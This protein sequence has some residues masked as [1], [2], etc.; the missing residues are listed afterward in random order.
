MYLHKSSEV[1]DDMQVSKVFSPG[2][3]SP[4][5]NKKRKLT[6]TQKKKYNF[7][8]CGQRVSPATACTVLRLSQ[9]IPRES[10]NLRRV[11]NVH[12]QKQPWAV[13]LFR[14]ASL[15]WMSLGNTDVDQREKKP[16]FKLCV[17]A[18]SYQIQT[19]LQPQSKLCS[20]KCW[21]N[22]ALKYRLRSQN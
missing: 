15:L 16:L 12:I 22:S 13:Y 9:D 8:S 17:K 5:V 2:F 19:P 10:F 1:N 6:L 4:S 7:L 3:I 18:S 14:T 20:G 21:I 11:R